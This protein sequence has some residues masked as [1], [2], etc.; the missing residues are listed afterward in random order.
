MVKQLSAYYKSKMQL[1]DSL[2]NPVYNDYAIG[3][4]SFVIL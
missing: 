2:T 1:E 4:Y 3:S